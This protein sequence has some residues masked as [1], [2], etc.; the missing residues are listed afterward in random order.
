MPVDIN[1]KNDIN[2]IND[3]DDINVMN[4][5]NDLVTGF[6]NVELLKF[7]FRFKFF[8]RNTNTNKP[9]PFIFNFNFFTGTILNNFVNKPPK[10]KQM[11]SIK[12]SIK[13]T[14][15]IENKSVVL[16]GVYLQPFC[17]TFFT[18]FSIFNF[19]FFTGT[20]CSIGRGGA[21]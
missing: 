1:D 4:D 3:I 7:K 9:L 16:S 19:N 5:I 15:L 8:T 12:M 13:R 17:S 20:F 18:L 21:P 6:V 14:K 2:D 10:P 11:R